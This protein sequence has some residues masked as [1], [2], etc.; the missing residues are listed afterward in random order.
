MHTKMTKNNFA[1]YAE[2]HTYSHV[3]Q[4]VVLVGVQVK[5]HLESS[6]VPSH[7]NMYQVSET[8]T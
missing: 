2:V 1:G 6:L 4:I 8:W 3:L 5:S 7:P